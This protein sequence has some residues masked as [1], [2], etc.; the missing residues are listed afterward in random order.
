ME[1]RGFCEVDTPILGTRYAG[2]EAKPFVTEVDAISSM[3][4]Q[5]LSPE[6]HLRRYNF[7]VIENVYNFC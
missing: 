2:E 1:A 7:G 3:A 5:N 4:Y 6:L